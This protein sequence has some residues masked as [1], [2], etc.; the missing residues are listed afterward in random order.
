MTEKLYKHTP[1][2]HV[3]KNVNAIHE[4]EKAAGNFNQKIAVGLTSVFQAMPTFWLIIA[5]IV[6]WIAAN[7]TIVHFDPLPW[8][9]LLCLASVPQLPLMIVI[10][11]GQGLL[12]RKQELQSE[13]QYNTTMKTYHDIEEIMQHLVAQ[14]AELLRHTKML[15]H[16][17]SAAGI[18][19]EQLPDVLPNDATIP[20]A[21]T[22]G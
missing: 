13:E 19:P 10:M 18:T 2:P 5:W 11:V 21:G 14:D 6:L 8:P 3:P 4:A 20:A 22:Q 17:L 7:A 9:L 16:L 15:I 12:G 1:Y